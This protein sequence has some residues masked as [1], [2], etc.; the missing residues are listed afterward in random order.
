MDPRALQERV[1]ALGWYHTIDLGQG[2]VTPGIFNTLRYVDRYGIPE[3]LAGLSVLDI[4][5]YNGFFTIEAKRRGA[6]RVVAMDRWGLPDSPERTGFDLAV[7]ATGVDV[8]SVNGDVYELTPAI[9]G[10]F[11]LVFFFGVLYHLRY[12]LLALERIAGVTRG[13]LL[14]ETHL[15]ALAMTRPA[16]A[17]YPGAE[18]EGDGTNWCGPNP[19]AVEAMLRVAGFA[20]VRPVSYTVR[21]RYEDVGMET[22]GSHGRSATRDRHAR[23]RERPGHYPARRVPRNEITRTL[24]PRSMPIL[25]NQDDIRAAL[26]RDPIWGVYALS[27]LDATL[28]PRTK[29]FV[30]DLT[31]VL[32]LYE[33]TILFSTGPGGVREA[34]DHVKWPVHLQVQADVLAEVARY[35]VISAAKTMVRMAW[36]GTKTE[37]ASSGVARR[38]GAADVPALQALYADGDATGEAP[39]FFF[40]SMVTDGVFFGMD[41]GGSL[42]AAAGTHVLARAENAAA[43]GNVYTRRDRRGRGLGRVVTSAVLDELAGIGTIGLNVRA[44]NDA[45]IRMYEGLGFAA[46]ASSPRHW[47]RAGGRLTST[48]KIH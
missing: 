39:D 48:T 29:W 19:E 46:T 22:R 2:V 23:R 11:D 6:Q 37:R 10:Q 25:T 4:G 5:A 8:E 20:N 3:R 12:P 35:A 9:A 34:L 36:S 13:S 31:L 24:R 27:D 33:T 45:A 14:L 47:R 43:I 17:F 1:N 28:F 30:P 32:D 21:S 40:P 41:E 18:L 38:L 16:M 44:D 42:V 26:R 15:D 7:E